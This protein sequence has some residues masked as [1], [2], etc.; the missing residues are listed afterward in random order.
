VSEFRQELKL[1]PVSW[2]ERK[3]KAVKEW[4]RLMPETNPRRGTRGQIMA[5]VGFGAL[6]VFVVIQN[7][8]H[9]LFWPDTKLST[10]PLLIF[11]AGCYLFIMTG[12]LASLLKWKPMDPTDTE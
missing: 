12:A 10:L 6:A 9:Y 3:V 2:L 8:I 4:H 5:G 1:N 11:G 7:I